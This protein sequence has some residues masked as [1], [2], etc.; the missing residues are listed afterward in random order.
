VAPASLLGRAQ[1]AWAGAA[2]ERIAR[3]SEPVSE[4]AGEVTVACSSAVWANELSLLSDDLLGRLN[5]ALGSAGSSAAV[6]AL[7][8]VT[9]P[10][11]PGGPEGRN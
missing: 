6:R 7:R 10:P 11:G 2:G 1:R 9:R 4:R 5:A 3:E 8:F